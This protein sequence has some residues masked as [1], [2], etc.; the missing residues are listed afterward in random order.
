M[1]DAQHGVTLDSNAL[2][3]LN[4]TEARALLDTA[5]TQIMLCINALIIRLAREKI[6]S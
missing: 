1:G 4:S 2:S 5:S 6:L 3:E